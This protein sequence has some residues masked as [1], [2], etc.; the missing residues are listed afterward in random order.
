M[1]PRP[2]R[3]P[4]RGRTARTSARTSAPPGR[5]LLLDTHTLLWWLVGNA[6]LSARARAVIAEP[7][8]VVFVSAAS[9]W[10]I[11]TKVRLGKLP[12]PHGVTDSLAAHVTAQGFRE[13][14]ISLEH[15]R[16]AGRLP[17]PH[18][19]PFDRMLIAQAQAEGLA[20]VSNEARFDAYEVERV[21]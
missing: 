17:G 13:L 10:E 18:K 1:S 8:A 6:Q 19:D 11:A 12:D 15:G 20:L 14:P 9:G 21:W 2:A 5:R 3:G 7:F 16:R 4:A